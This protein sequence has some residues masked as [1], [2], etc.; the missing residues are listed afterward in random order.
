MEEQC[1]KKPV[2]IDIDGV[3]LDFSLAFSTWFNKENPNYKLGGKR[4]ICPHNA[5]DWQFNHPDNEWITAKIIE[6]LHIGTVFPL[7][8]R[9]IPEQLMRLQEKY[10]IHLVTNYPMKMAPTRIATL[11]KYSIPYDNITFTEEYKGEIVARINP[12]AVIEDSPKN[13]RSIVAK[14]YHVYV[15]SFW[16]YTTL[17]KDMEKIKYYTTF[18]DVVDELLA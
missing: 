14:G 6:F 17:V 8:D 10:Y 13:I 9:D 16:N 4:W 1:S 3:I 11:L 18:K 2:V 15:P 5:D 7:I 12:V